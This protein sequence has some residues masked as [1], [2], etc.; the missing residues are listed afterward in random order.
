MINL[1]TPLQDSLRGYSRNSS[2]RFFYDSLQNSL[3]FSLQNS[4]RHS[5]LFS[6]VDSLRDSLWDS[7]HD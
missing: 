3:L 1:G 4:L 2:W 7:F 6:L 5:L